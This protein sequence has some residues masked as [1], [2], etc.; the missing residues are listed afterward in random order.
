MGWNDRLPEDPYI[1]PESFYRDR[2]DYEAW[3]EYVEMSLEKEARSGLTSQTLDPQTLQTPTS[4]E[5][6][7]RRS[8]LAR[9][10]AGIFGQNVSKNSRQEVAKRSREE[11][12]DA[13]F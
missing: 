2:D 5:P 7:L 10:W 12:V 11:N 9:I 4:Q 8:I 1:P 6:P 3:L 13:P